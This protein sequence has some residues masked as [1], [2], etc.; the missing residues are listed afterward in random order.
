MVD[1]AAIVAEARTWI[2]TRFHHQARLKGVGVDCA[3]VVMGTAQSLG[4][5]AEDV[6]G[7]ARHPD[8]GQLETECARQMEQIPV[9]DAQ[10][11]DVLLFKFDS[12]P[13]HLA[14]IGDYVHGGL[15]IIHAYSVAR[16][17]VETRLDDTWRS[18]I[19]A[20]YKLKGLI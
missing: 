2:G 15:S 17:V 18:R 11:G 7:Y 20:A 3:G 12:E 4:L 1:R 5:F 6:Q 19:T 13:Q 8:G 14:I 16:N 10:A 9:A